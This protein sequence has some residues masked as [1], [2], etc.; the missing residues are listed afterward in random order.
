MK[1]IEILIE[2]CKTC[3]HISPC[4]RFCFHPLMNNSEGII[5][6]P[7]WVI[8][9]TCPLQDAIDPVTTLNPKVY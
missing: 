8:L 3:V 2:T 5:L 7:K 1:K 9:D 6:N 4:K